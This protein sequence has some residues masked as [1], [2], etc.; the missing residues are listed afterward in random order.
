VRQYREIRPEREWVRWVECGWCSETGDDAQPH[1]VRPDGCLDIVYSCEEGLRAVG[2]MTAQQRY[3]F[4]PG[5]RMAGVRFQPGMATAFLGA[6]ASEFTDKTI[7]LEQ[8]WGARA[9]ELEE[10]L[11]DARTPGETVRLL[12]QGIPR[13]EREASPVQR[14]IEEIAAQRGNCDLEWAA[15]Q[16]RLSE[17]QFRR[18]CLEESGLAPKQL[19]RVLRFRFACE[20]ADRGEHWP[21]IAA[22]AGYFDQAHLI[23]DFHEFAGGAPMAVFSNTRDGVRP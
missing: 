9:R 4:E 7:A 20:L 12:L 23:R 16:A 1:V 2:A 8:V 18:R 13:P 6:A 14:A 10:R 3:E 15:R 21:A 5:K 22:E 19:S 17:R 11:R